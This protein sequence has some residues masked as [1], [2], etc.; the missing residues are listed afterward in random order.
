ME[1]SAVNMLALFKKNI[2]K[3]KVE[4]IRVLAHLL[5]DYFYNSILGSQSIDTSSKIILRY[6]TI[7]P[8]PIATVRLSPSIGLLASVFSPSVGSSPRQNTALCSFVF[9]LLPHCRL[10]HSRTGG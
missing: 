6:V 1:I 9:Q 2:E 3:L 10:G 5:S 8:P 4:N 7:H